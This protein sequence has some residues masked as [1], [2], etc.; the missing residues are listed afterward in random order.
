MIY[1][2]KFSVPTY[3]VNSD[4]NRKTSF[5]IDISGESEEAVRKQ[6]LTLQEVGKSSGLQP[7]GMIQA[8]KVN[9]RISVFDTK[10]DHIAHQINIGISEDI[11]AHNPEAEKQLKSM[12]NQAAQ[13]AIKEGLDP[14]NLQYF[15]VNTKLN[16]DANYDDIEQTKEA[17]VNIAE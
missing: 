16:Q 15:I 17:E 10:D 4:S 13:V 14:D 3:G 1:S 5:W 2:V 8:S 7:E 9:P 6:V 12:L 11:L